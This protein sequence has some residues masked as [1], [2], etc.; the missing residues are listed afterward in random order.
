MQP[1]H[2]MYV[3]GTNW[4]ITNNT[5]YDNL[6]IGI[7]VAGYAWCADG[8]CYGGGSRTHADPS[9]AGASGFMIANNTIAYNE[10]GPGITVWQADTTNGQI[11]NNILYENGQH[12]PSGSPQ[13]ISLYN[14]GGRQVFKNNLFYASGAGATANIGGTTG[15]QTKYTESGD[16]SAN[17]NFVNAPAILTAGSL[18]FHLQ[19][20]S[21]AID[22]GLA[23]PEMASNDP[24]PDIGAS[25]TSGFTHPVTS[26]S[27]GAGGSGGS[28]S[29][30]GW[31]GISNCAR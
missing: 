15:W 29:G 1:D 30:K 7:Q 22:A 25:D 4:T 17:P 31:G 11:I 3:T 21:P 16:I 2:G 28:G 12:N 20:D 13:G 5:I 24:K 14:S 9:Y 6:A 19:P 10:H 26:T 27:D 8:N 18:D 23:I